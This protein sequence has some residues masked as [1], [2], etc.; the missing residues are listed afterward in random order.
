MS[1][2]TDATRELEA[3]VLMRQRT[4]ALQRETIAIAQRR[5]A[6]I[7]EEF[8]RR[9]IP[10][11]RE[12]AELTPAPTPQPAKRERPLPEPDPEWSPEEQAHFVTLVTGNK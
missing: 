2:L 3:L 4:L 1:R 9:A 8:D 12:I 11:Q 10:L 7:N 6:A 5:I